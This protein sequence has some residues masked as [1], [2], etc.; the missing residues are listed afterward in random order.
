MNIRRSPDTIAAPFGPYS[1][2]VEASSG[3]RL[4]YIA[5]QVG[6][7]KDGSVPDGIEAQA[8]GCWRNIAA[9]LAEA[10][11]GIGDLVKITTFL[12]RAQDTAAAGAAR[13]RH[14]GDS[15][16]A[17]TTVIVAG[18]VAANMLIEIEAVAAK[19]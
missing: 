3:S 16:P 1:Q 18:L 5:G 6:A 10:D 2:S 17:S 13:A 19:A 4:L 12:T 8:E 11:M 14:L 7:H 9:I 15:R